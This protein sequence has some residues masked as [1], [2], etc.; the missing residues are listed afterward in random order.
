M[1]N[2]NLQEN[3]KWSFYEFSPVKWDKNEKMILLGPLKL[4]GRLLQ[5]PH[6]KF[7]SLFLYYFWIGVL[8]ALQKFISNYTEF[9]PCQI[10]ITPF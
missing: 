10:D 2:S 1:K 5:V 8:I 3:I 6:Q 7:S 4:L 9:Q